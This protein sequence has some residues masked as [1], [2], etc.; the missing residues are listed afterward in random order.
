MIPRLADS[1][2]DYYFVSADCDWE[3][4]HGMQFLLENDVV[5]YCGDHTT[6]PDGAVWNRVLGCVD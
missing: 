5:L 4:E 1:V 3:A 2:E 6:L